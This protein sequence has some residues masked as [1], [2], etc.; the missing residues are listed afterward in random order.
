LYEKGIQVSVEE[1]DSLHLQRNAFHP[2]WNYMILPAETK[3]DL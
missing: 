3:Q 2:E 1:F